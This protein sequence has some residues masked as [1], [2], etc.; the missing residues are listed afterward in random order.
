MSTSVI[1]TPCEQVKSEIAAKLDAK[2]VTNYML[3]VVPSDQSGAAKVVGIW[4]AA[5][6]T[7]RVPTGSH[8]RSRR[9]DR[10]THHADAGS[11]AGTMLA[12]LSRARIFCRALT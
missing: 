2:H 7:P 4:V 6:I 9:T 11:G 5:R 3:D 8:N 12:E 1:A 10:L